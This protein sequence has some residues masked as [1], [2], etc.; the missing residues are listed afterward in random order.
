MPEDYMGDN[1]LCACLVLSALV[2]MDTSLACP[3]LSGSTIASRY[4]VGYGRKR[5]TKK[6]LMFCRKRQIQRHKG[7]EEWVEVTCLSPEVMA[8]SVPGFFPQGPSLHPW[9]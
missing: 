3:E 4:R 8:M 2:H 5:H 7:S 1:G 6:W 9:P